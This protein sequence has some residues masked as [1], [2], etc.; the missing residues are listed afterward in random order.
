LLFQGIDQEV[1]GPQDER[2]PRDPKYD[3]PLEHVAEPIASANYIPAY[4]SFL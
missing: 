3:E 1:V 2:E 4:Y